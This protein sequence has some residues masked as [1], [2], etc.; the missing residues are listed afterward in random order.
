MN[1]QLLWPAKGV[2]LAAEF[3]NRLNESLGSL[4]RAGAAVVAVATRPIKTITAVTPF[5]VLVIDCSGQAFFESRL[6]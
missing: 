6:A 1:G 5:F 3:L 4:V 2:E